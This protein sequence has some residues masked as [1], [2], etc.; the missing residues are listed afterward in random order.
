MS[1]VR[2]CNELG[3]TTFRKV[4]QFS[5]SGEGERETSSLL[6]LL[7]RVNLNHWTETLFGTS[8]EFRTKD[9]FLKPTDS[10]CYKES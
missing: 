3:N 10:E 4:D 5:S 1:L 7:E 2:I 6:G 8:F 9:K